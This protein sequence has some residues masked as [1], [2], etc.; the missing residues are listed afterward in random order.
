MEILGTDHNK[1]LDEGYKIHP[2]ALGWIWTAGL[3]PG[4]S[5]GPGLDS[6]IGLGACSSMFHRHASVRSYRVWGGQGSGQIVAQPGACNGMEL[7]PGVQSSMGMD[8]TMGSS[9]HPCAAAQ[10]QLCATAQP[11]F[12]A[13]TCSWLYDIQ[14]ISAPLLFW[15]PLQL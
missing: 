3:L 11:E 12:C 6:S 1:E 15:I 5:V 4:Q 7:E 10:T 13:T 8:M 9:P 14:S 2:R